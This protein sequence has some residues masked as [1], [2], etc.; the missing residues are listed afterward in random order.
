[1]SFVERYMT[2]LSESVPPDEREGIDNNTLYQ[3]LLILENST[4]EKFPISAE[5]LAHWMQIQNV[6]A[7]Y[8]RIEGRK[9]SKSGSKM[10]APYVNGRDYVVKWVTKESGQK[11][12]TIFVSLSCFKDILQ[13]M[14]NSR[15]HIIR[16]YFVLAE[17]LYRDMAHYHI[18]S[19]K[20]A[21]AMESKK[22]GIV[23]YETK[24]QAYLDSI[25]TKEGDWWKPGHTNNLEHRRTNLRLTYPALKHVFTKQQVMKHPEALEECF[26]LLAENWKLVCDEKPCPTEI[27]YS[28]DMPADQMWHACQD[29]VQYSKRRLQELL[30][31][32]A[33]IPTQHPTSINSPFTFRK[34]RRLYTLKN[35][36]HV[37]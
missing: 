26:K 7:F 1:M 30:K 19:N 8:K 10:H 29:T 22:E 16:K 21:F 36:K 31:S 11:A 37:L 2:L 4:T 14:T 17:M 20:K 3:F 6:E 13:R 27:H 24:P 9:F 25:T 35:G 18:D 5:W 15:S 34:G 32:N 23:D 12:K 33:H 28:K